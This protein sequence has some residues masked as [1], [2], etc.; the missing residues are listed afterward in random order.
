MGYLDAHTV[1]DL[2]EEVRTL[3]AALLVAWL[4][5]FNN[6][7]ESGDDEEVATQAAWDAVEEA[8][9]AIG[10]GDLSR[11]YA[12][13]DAAVSGRLMLFP[14]GTFTH[15]EYGTLEFD[16]AFFE[17]IKQNFEDRVLGQTE[18]FIDVDHDKGAA[19]GW[20]KALSIESDGMFARVEWTSPGQELIASKQFAFFSPWFGPFVDAATGT[21]YENVL[22]GGGLTNIPFLKVLPAV[23]LWEPGVDS[24]AR[25]RAHA[26]GSIALSELVRAPRRRRRD[27]R[28]LATAIANLRAGKETM[29]MADHEQKVLKELT[30]CEDGRNQYGILLQE[31]TARGAS[32]S[33]ARAAIEKKFPLLADRVFNEM[34]TASGSPFRR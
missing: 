26:A 3:P 5:T 20:I 8:R 29:D 18:P 25:R 11:G 17:A 13:S 10:L 28:H 6:H 12:L 30:G 16:D 7:I 1:A 27:G 23:E 2:P 19:M 21:K 24:P 32:I 15:P 31:A 4:V 9:A 33:D 14:R 34:Q 22:R